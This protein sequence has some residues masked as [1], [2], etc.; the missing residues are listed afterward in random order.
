M[1]FIK[2]QLF[3]SRA[4]ALLAL[5]AAPAIGTANNDIQYRIVVAKDGSGDFKSIQQ[6]VNSAR[7]FPDRRITVYVKNGVYTEK[8]KIHEWN[9]LLSLLGESREGT[10]IAWG[11]HFK[12][13]KLGRNSTFHTAT[14]QVDGDDFRAENLTVKN[15][16]GPVGQGIALAANADRASFR[17]TGF[18]GN[19]DTLY[20]TGAGKRLYFSDCYIEGTTDFIFGRATALFENCRLHSKADSFIT[21]ASTPEGIEYGFVFRNCTLTAAE[22]VSKVYLGRPWRPYA[23]TVFI[24]TEM[25]AHI[26]PEGWSTWSG[27]AGPETENVFYAEHANTG[28]GAAAGKR[29]GWSRQLSKRQARHYTAE[30]ILGVHLGKY[31]FKQDEK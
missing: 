15:T 18:I 30:N 13:I 4:I 26:L 10:I 27:Q 7:S 14:L 25:G 19:Q 31:W 11:D 5:L 8:V 12:K 29:I 24:D 3:L 28:P 1:P 22:G 17:N 16:A 6:A 20:L 21:A 23:R 2:P 9:T